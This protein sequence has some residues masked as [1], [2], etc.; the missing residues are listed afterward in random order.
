MGKL[1]FS[2]MEQR[3]YD[4][5]FKSDEVTWQALLLDVVKTQDMDPWNIDVSELATQYIE[6]LQKMQGMDLRI[7]GKVILAAA[8]LLKFKSDFLMEND[9]LNFDKLMHPEDYTEDALYEGSAQQIERPDPN[10]L[11][12]I[13][14][15]PQ[16]R[17]RKVSI[18]ELVEALKQALEVKK[19]RREILAAVNIPLP[20][21]K[22]DISVIIHQLYENICRFLG[23]KEYITFSELVPVHDKKA[24][25]TAFLPLLH[26]T[27]E[28]KIDLSQQ[29]HF[30]EIEIS[31]PKQKELDVGSAQHEVADTKKKHDFI[32]DALE[33]SSKKKRK[34]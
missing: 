19:R 18:Y 20:E 34:Q 15:T 6:T 11:R 33:E 8:L 10:D 27:N 30:G 9:M 22:V 14:K 29:V 12:L 4:L 17:K 25:V 26:L 24:V 5:I 1:P 16:P 7:S 32:N 31:Y 3:I 23:N 28:R 2:A 21:K 13:P